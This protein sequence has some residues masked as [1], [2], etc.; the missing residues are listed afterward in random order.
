[1]EQYSEDTL[2]GLPFRSVHKY[3]PLRAKRLEHIDKVTYKGRV[4]T[5]EGNE[6]FQV[7]DHLARGIYDE[8][9]V[10]SKDHLHRYYEQISDQPDEEGFFLYRPINNIREAYRVST[11]FILHKNDGTIMKGKANDYIVRDHNDAWIVD[12]KIFNQTYRPA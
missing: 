6:T 9:W 4:N 8:E 1:M 2:Q 10:I 11:S 7:G 3:A 5:L 12:G